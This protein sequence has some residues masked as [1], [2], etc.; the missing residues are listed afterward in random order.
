M[1]WSVGVTA[2]KKMQKLWCSTLLCVACLAML[3][4]QGQQPTLSFEKVRTSDGFFSKMVRILAQDKQG[5][6]WLLTAEG[7]FKYDGYNFQYISQFPGQSFKPGDVLKSM[8]I[9]SNGHIWLGT[10]NN[11]LTHY[12]P[13]TGQSKLYS[14]QEGQANSL[15][16]N[17]VYNIT[18]GRQGHIWLC[19][20]TGLSR[21]NPN[22]GLINQYPF[23]NYAFGQHTGHN[24]R[25]FR[26]DGKGGVWLGS[27]EAGLFHFD[28]RQ[29]LVQQ[30]RHKPADPYSLS[31]DN[32]L[33]MFIDSKS[34]LWVYTFG[35][36]LNKFNATT[37]R[38]T[39]Y[40]HNP[41]TPGT[42]SS[43][44]IISVAEGPEGH[45]W[46]GTFG[47]GLN[48][49]N[50][51]TGQAEVF[52]HDPSNSSSL[53]HNFVNGMYFDK[54]GNLWAGVGSMLTKCNLT[55]A[56]VEH[57]RHN[58]LNP[59]SLSSSIV[60]AIY[61]DSQ[62]NLWVGTYTAGLNLRKAG[63]SN[64]QH[65]KHQR[66]SS[67]G[68]TSNII[69]TITEGPAGNI[70]IGTMG[71][72]VNIYNPKTNQFTPINSRT[73]GA[74]FQLMNNFVW[75]VHLTSNAAWFATR[76]GLCSYNFNT[77]ALTLVA[78][79]S[80]KAQGYVNAEV[81]EISPALDGGL[82]L[83][84]NGSG[85]LHYNIQTETYTQYKHVN[86]EPN[87]LAEDRLKCVYQ[88]PDGTVW[89][90]T[91]ASGLCKFSPPTQQF[92]VYNM[93]HGLPANLVYGILQDAQ[94]NLWLSTSNGLSKFNPLVERFENYTE[95]HGLQGTDFNTKSYFQSVSGRMY[96]GGGNGFNS[97]DPRQL[98]KNT[99]PPPMAFTSLMINNKA[100]PLATIKQ[101]NASIRLPYKGNNTLLFEFSALDLSEPSKNK[102][103]YRIQNFQE[104]WIYLR[105][106]RDV[107]LSGLP[108]GKYALEVKASN[109]HDVWTENSLR[110][111]V[112]IT[113]NYYQT[114]WFKLLVLAAVLGLIGLFFRLRTS[115]MTKRNALLQHEIS[116]RKRMAKE[117]LRLIEE[118]ESKN[119]ELEGKNAELERFTYTVS[120]D[121]KSPLVTIKGFLGFIEK[122]VDKQQ[123]HKLRGDLAHISRAANNMQNLLDDLLELSKVGHVVKPNKVV[124][125]TELANEAVRQVTG[126]ILQNGVLVEV[127]PDMPEMWVDKTR[128]I[129]VYQNLIDNAVKFM[130]EQPHP[131]IQVG[132]RRND[133]LT[134]FFVADN[135]KGIEK[136][137]LEKVFG[138]F[139]RLDQ[140]IDGTGVGLTLVKRIIDVHLG[141]I[142]AESEGLGKGT[143]FYFTLGTVNPN[144]SDL[145]R[146]SAAPTTAAPEQA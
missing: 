63:A 58:P 28:P 105:N 46:V 142:W 48:R 62:K 115:S 68:L 85:L 107:T 131:R 100:V 39:H 108:P 67:T 134:E 103:A 50:P 18:E 84:T 81:I 87:S 66:G 29:G 129:E 19:N 38:F 96:F 42:I 98:P 123:Y 127:Q 72:G 144:N 25:G 53:P 126:Q 112:Q 60:N 88:S 102:Y 30:F 79:A 59:Q 145:P 20:A 83:A 5:F 74:G 94:G 27:R 14:N 33:G 36:G 77:Q 44:R 31:T 9:D 70:W 119:T 135:G 43:N 92:R 141:Q 146:A 61:E 37:R 7:L 122:A 106:K 49:L 99:Q 90:G 65:F 111:N 55:S 22:T 16:D 26:A 124:S 76:E 95:T 13:E 54:N 64:W 143:T 97:F 75:D 35:G 109:N 104:Q 57:I 125:M 130:G 69:S 40:K 118:L 12:N 128:V 93:Q 78:G 137:Y 82:W 140:D 132:C 116:E 45:I 23:T 113:P 21:L 120:H 11:G 71:G 86:N 114:W 80:G 51:N 24:N 6:L 121:L 101:S 1:F 4:A 91:F 34:N 8:Y 2:I 138:L 110:V 15:L 56:R 133:Q 52:K 89:V 10:L 17:A 117:R 41:A 136:E 73:A 3:P 32:V 47:G 139:D